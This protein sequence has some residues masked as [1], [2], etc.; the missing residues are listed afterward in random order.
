MNVESG[1]KNSRDICE[2][3]GA[4]GGGEDKI[5]DSFEIIE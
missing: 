2:R 4:R 3:G 1:E 5:T